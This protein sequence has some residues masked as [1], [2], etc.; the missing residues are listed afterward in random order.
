MVIWKF[1]KR[2]RGL[3][4]QTY[5]D[6]GTRGPNCALASKGITVHEVY[7]RAITTLPEEMSAAYHCHIRDRSSSR[8]LEER[9]EKSE[10]QHF[11]PI[12]VDWGLFG[13]GR[14]SSWVAVGREG[15]WEPL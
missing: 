2:A 14:L 13:V 3:R 4:L 6:V 8:K 12:V 15:P 10:E 1:T 5:N 9:C 11:L 7:S